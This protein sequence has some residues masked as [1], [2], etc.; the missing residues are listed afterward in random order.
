MTILKFK[1]IGWEFV[2]SNHPILANTI[3]ESFPTMKGVDKER[4][5][6]LIIETVL[7]SGGSIT[8][9]DDEDTED[10]DELL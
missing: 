8:I 5:A 2:E 6:G 9:F 7:N 3:E 1:K 10:F 4:L